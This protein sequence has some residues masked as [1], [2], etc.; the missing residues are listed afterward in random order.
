VI[1]ATAGLLDVHVPPVVGVKV[2]ELPAHIVG[3]LAVTVGDGTTTKGPDAADEQPVEV[4]VHTNVTVPVVKPVT[5][6]E[7]L[8]VATKGLLLAQVPPVDGVKLVVDSTHILSL[9]V[10]ATVGTG[11]TV[12]VMESDLHPVKV[13]VKINLAEPATKPV[14]TPALVTF[15]VV[16][17]TA[18][19]VPPDT[20]DTVVVDPTQTAG[21]PVITAVGG[22]FTVTGFVV[23]VHPVAALVNVNVAVPEATAVTTPVEAST[24]ATD[25]LLL[26]HVPPEFGDKVVVAPIQIPVEPVILTVGLGL[27]VI[28]IVSEHVVVLYTY[29]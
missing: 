5:N 2:V 9:P 6:P 21:V 22:G 20:G 3:G 8:M 4:C 17:G 27:T 7:L 19:Q 1:V 23:A 28:V 25:A 18:N 26:A 29:L 24:V 13:S 10:K 14:T 12:I 15:T 11:V 16:F